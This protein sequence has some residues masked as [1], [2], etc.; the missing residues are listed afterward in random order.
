MPVKGGYLA[1]AGIGVVVLWSGIKGHKWSTVLRDTI[2][3]QPTGSTIDQP[4]VSSSAAYG[5]GT[6]LNT[7]TAPSLGAGGS[8][9]KNVAI[10]KSMALL[11]GWSGQQWTDLYN[12][13]TRE[14]GW[15]N[16]AQNPSSGAYGVAQALP[17]TKYPAAGRPPISS[18][19]V[20]IWWGLGYIKERYGS[21]SGAWAHEESAGWY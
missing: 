1:V 5:Y 21:P 16:K 13:W 18:A 19:S 2:S 11:F 10:G 3:G 20:Q 12:L 6:G 17:P 14:S 4:I 7:G 15:N 8:H 9:A